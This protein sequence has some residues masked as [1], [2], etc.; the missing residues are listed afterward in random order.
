M[1]KFKT[2]VIF[3]TA[4]LLTVQAC[5]A[6]V[7]LEAYRAYIR[8]L[9]A[10]R[11]GNAAQAADEY[12]LTAELDANAAFVYRDLA[13]SLWQAG[14]TDEAVEAANKLSEFYGDD[15]STLLFL[16]SFYLLV[17]EP[18]LARQAW[19][20]VIKLDPGNETALLYLAAYHSS[21]NNPEKAV[22]YWNEY[23]K[24]EPGSA[25][26]YYQLGLAEEKLR[27][28]DKA[29]NYYS[30][31]LSLKPETPEAHLSL[32]QLYE[33]EEDFTA[34][35]RAYEQ[36]LVLVPDNM[37]VLLYLGGLHY[38][39]KD[40]DAAEN[41]FQRAFVLNPEDNTV[42][43]WLGVIAENRKDWDS[44]IKYFEIISRS[45]NNTA[46]MIRL[47]YYHAAKS[48][49]VS[50][51]RYLKQVVKMDPSNPVAHYLLGLG[52]SDLKKYSKAEKSF[53]Q[54]KEFNRKMEGVSFH[55]GMI[56]DQTGRREKAMREMKAELRNNPNFAPALNYVGYTYIEKGEKL[57][58]AEGMIRKAIEIEPDNGSY[59][60][61]LGWFYFQKGDHAAAQEPLAKA[62][63]LYPDTLI[64]EH[65]GDNFMKLGRLQ[66][67]WNS[68]RQA[69]DL[70][71]RNKKA[72]KK[73]AEAEKLSAPEQVRAYYLER[74]LANLA[75]IKTFKAGFSASGNSDGINFRFA[76]VFRYSKPGLW[77]VD[78]LGSFMAP[79]LVIIQNEGLAFYPEALS[80]EYSRLKT[81]LIGRAQDYL[82]PKNMAELRSEKAVSVKKSGRY[83][84]SVGEKSLNI[85]KANCTIKEYQPS[86]GT[87][88]RFNAYTV[89]DGFRVPVDMDVFSKSDKFSAGIKFGSCSVNKPADAGIF[90][91]P[92]KAALD[93]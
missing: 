85:D 67:A 78:V 56:Y 12:K 60:D 10:A 69:L 66:D 71:P 57:E 15:L 92:A 62:A 11:S 50:A 35:A 40:F 18:Y 19:E 33:R 52:Y 42:C 4:S 29:I 13:F 26:A 9:L 70:K 84:Y 74:A 55:L 86:A 32:A 46:V 30:K 20:K 51:L 83:I 49:H 23:L 25:Q 3:I 81:G 45:D 75:D 47:S 44:A 8:G 61:S 48:D 14:R 79:E 34:A 93:K 90:D 82:S 87:L 5:F 88:I 41:S 7:P 16:G 54:A 37:T 53:L 31:S 43:F 58:E 38:R 91:P 24:K 65:Q 22:I 89:C 76:G 72:K 59:V 27:N 77:R 80:E 73:L 17:N 1:R 39:L 36:Y 2:T 28:I 64:F 63:K 21:D 6:A 68:Y